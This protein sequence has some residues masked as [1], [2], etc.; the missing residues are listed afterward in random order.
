MAAVLSV[1]A[2]EGSTYVVTATFTDEDGDPVP[3]DAV[4]PGDRMYVMP[5]T[6]VPGDS[7]ISFVVEFCEVTP[8][9][10]FVYPVPESV[11]MLTLM[12]QIEP[13]E[14]DL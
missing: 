4:T 8:K 11:H 5:E 13:K 2:V 10:L 6:A 1:E 9:G 14:R 7:G 3:L 12:A